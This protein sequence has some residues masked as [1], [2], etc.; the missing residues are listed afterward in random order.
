M[1]YARHAL[2]GLLSEFDDVRVTVGNDYKDI[3]RW[4]PG[5]DL[6]ITYVAGP[7][8]TDEEAAY[9]EQWMSAGGRWLA[10]HGSSGGKAVKFQA[11]EGQRKRMVKASHHGAIGSFF[12]NHPPIRR[13]RVDVANDAH[14]LTAG[15]PSHFEVADELYLIEL[16]DRASTHILL[17]TELE[18]DPSPPGF[19]FAYQEDTSRL[20]GSAT[21]VI[22]YEKTL[23][24]GG[25]AYVALGH[26]HSPQSN[27]QPLVDESVAPNGTPPN[28]FRGSWQEEAL[29]TLIRNGIS[30]GIRAA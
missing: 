7:F 8:T 9:L 16:Q 6:L 23:G 28:P 29:P 18:D 10:L 3:E 11:P 25:V 14:P 21:R 19:G 24:K 5:T 26:C 27:T 4:L 22:G 2:L 13:F 30:W 1:D 17:T 15:L 20:D 12:L